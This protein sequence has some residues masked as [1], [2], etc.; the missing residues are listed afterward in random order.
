MEVPSSRMSF[1]VWVIVLAMRLT[2]SVGP[3]LLTRKGGAVAV[4]LRKARA[5]D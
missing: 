2:P 1:T 3:P 5:K 4:R